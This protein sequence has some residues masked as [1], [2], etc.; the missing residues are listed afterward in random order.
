[1]KKAKTAVLW[2]LTLLLVA[3][4]LNAGI[5][6]FFEDGGWSWMFRNWGYPVWFRIF[7]GVMEVAA[8]VLLLIPRTAKYGALIVIVIMLGAIATFAI[9]GRLQF[10]TPAIITLAVASIVLAMRYSFQRR[11]DSIM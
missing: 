4:F 8:A 11:I 10:A 7:I 2:I 1:M 6:K 5:R 9:F 3:S